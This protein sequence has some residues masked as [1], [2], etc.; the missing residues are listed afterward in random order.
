MPLRNDRHAFSA[1]VG[2][3]IDSALHGV[4]IALTVG[5]TVTFSAS[6]RGPFTLVAKRRDCL[7]LIPRNS[8]PATF[9]TAASIIT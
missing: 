9:N 8:L 4:E 5:T 2:H 7:S 6:A 1:V 3:E